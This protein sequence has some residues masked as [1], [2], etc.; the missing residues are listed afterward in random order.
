MSIPFE[1]ASKTHVELNIYDLRGQRVETLVSKVMD[2]GDHE[3]EWNAVS[4]ASGVYI[5]ALESNGQMITK[6][7]ILIK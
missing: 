5:Y 4:F 2:M 1:L 7:M 6:K 3:L